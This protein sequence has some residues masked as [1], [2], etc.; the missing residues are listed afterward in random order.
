MPRRP[1]LGAKAMDD[2][3]RSML[4][5]GCSK[6]QLGVIFG[7]D[8]RK[9]DEKIRNVPPS[10]ERMGYPIWRIRDVAPFLV[11]A[12]GD[13]EEAIKKMSPADL[14]PALTKEFWSAQHARLKY[15]EDRGDL[16]RTADVVE[17]MSTV[18]KKL[19]M[20]ILLVTDQVERQTHLTDKQR[21]IIIG[22]MDGTLN[23]LADSLV[24]TFKHEPDRRFDSGWQQPDEH[25]PAE[26]L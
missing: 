23:Q 13:F 16:W 26:G 2:E 18:F 20:N 11:P 19:R 9:V 15:E 14:P 21:E 12:Q 25:D 8:N 6:S 22:L 3:G 17:R 5:E 24:N 4:Y 7:I 10:G 1:G